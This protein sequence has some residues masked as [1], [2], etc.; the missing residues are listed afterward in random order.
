MP[1]INQSTQPSKAERAVA[2]FCYLTFGLV[3][4][5]YIIISGRS[6]QSP[7]FRFHFLQSIILAILSI[8]LGWTVQIFSSVLGQTLSLV[9]NVVPAFAFQGQFIAGL[10]LKVVT[11][12]FLLLPIYAMILAFLGKYAEIPFISNMVRRQ[13]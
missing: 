10:T 1:W 9:G 4:L 5:L 13:M 3:G 11:N 8:L 7:F 6:Q 12:A 2:G